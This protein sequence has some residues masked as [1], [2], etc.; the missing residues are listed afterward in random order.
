VKN[1][2][3][4]DFGCQSMVG[5]IKHILVKHPKD[6][7][8]NQLKI[9]GESKKLNYL[10]KPDYKKSISDY[11]RLIDFFKTNNIEIHYLPIDEDTSLDSIYTHDPCIISNSGVILSNMG[12][13]DRQTE[14]EAIASYFNSINIPILGQIKS[15]GTLEGGDV[16][17]I[18]KR[19]VAVG[20]GYRTNAEG[21]RQLKSLLKS[22]VDKVI[23]VP[24][25]HW[26]GPADC[27]HLMSNVSPIDHDLYLVYSKLLPVSFRE[28]LLER[29]IKLVE[30]PDE[31]Y[32]SMGCNVLAVSPR[33]VIM[34]NKNPITQQRL[35]AENV[36]IHTY[37]GSEISI[38]GSGGPT[39]LTR[40][41]MRSL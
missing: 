14:P 16:V 33:K 31:E 7:Y 4:N 9:D 37:D 40:P 41:F 22:D 24:L 34:I 27:L 8:Q 29:G 18:D 28:Y 36:E 10:S 3:N 20:E 5:K 38:K 39:C 13:K 32:D 12:K 19:T 15:P 11:E 21:I 1:K 35:E 25:P 6:A 30:V 17:W 2:L 23:T 26:T